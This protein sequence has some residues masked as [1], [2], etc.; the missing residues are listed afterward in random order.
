MPVTTEPNCNPVSI[1]RDPSGR[2]VIGVC[3]GLMLLAVSVR[4]LVW[5]NIGDDINTP[6][7]ISTA[8]YVYDTRNL[9]NGDVS[10]FLRGPDP[11]GDANVLAHP[12]G[13]PIMLAGIL[14]VYDSLAAVRLVQIVFCSFAAVLVFFIAAEFLDWRFA[15]VA[16]VLTAISP[17]LSY[18]S[19]LVLP[20][21]L[22]VPPILLAILIMVRSGRNATWVSLCACGALLGLSIWFR[23]NGL[24]LPVFIAA[25]VAPFMLPS[26]RRWRSLAI[27]GFA[28]M[29]VAP[30]TIRN[31]VVF[32]RF[33]P[34]SLGTGPTLAEGIGDYDHAGVYGM[35]HTDLELMAAEAVWHNRPEYA[36]S[37]YVPD[38]IERE[39]DRTARSFAIIRAHPVWFSSVLVRRASMM[40]RMERVPTVGPSDTAQRGPLPLRWLGDVLRLLQ[41]PFIT[42]VFLPLS[43]V[44][45]VLMW[46]QHEQRPIAVLLLAGIFYYVAVHSWIH[47][48]YRYV[49]LIPQIEIIFA[50]VTVAAISKR[51]RASEMRAK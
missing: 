22:S 32:H 46:R 51:F 25:A 38:G 40:L 11:P 39:R 49:Q 30:I 50:T 43:L 27:V 31:A 37:F 16:G 23:A 17:Q 5:F 29:V 7:S 19:L 12:P 21:S 45:F 6:M 42:A 36:N 20:D 48:E 8:G 10:A 28:I 24:L 13:Y 2:V 9:M 4:L 47:T 15:L 44:G 14:S 26:G 1:K 35:P 34:V 33:I 41:R 3:L 18:N